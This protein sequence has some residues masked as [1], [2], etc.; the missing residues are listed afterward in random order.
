MTQ[1]KLISFNGVKHVWQ[2]PGEEYKDKCLADNQ[3]C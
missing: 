1:D 3:V 2:K